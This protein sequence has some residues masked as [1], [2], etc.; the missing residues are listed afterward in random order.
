MMLNCAGKIP[1]PTS[2][3]EWAALAAGWT[4][5]ACIDGIDLQQSSLFPWCGGQ[6]IDPQHCIACSGVFIAEQSTA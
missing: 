2:A 4:N 6:G 5:G 3:V 1:K